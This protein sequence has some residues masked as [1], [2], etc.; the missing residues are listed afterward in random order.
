[1]SGA[2]RTIRRR[3]L[4]SPPRPLPPPPTR[5][6][7]Y[8]RTGLAHLATSSSLALGIGTRRTASSTRLREPVRRS[9]LTAHPTRPRRHTGVSSCKRRENSLGV[10]DHSL[11][12]ANIP[13]LLPGPI[14]TRPS[15]SSPVRRVLTAPNLHLVLSRRHHR[16]CKCYS[17]SGLFGRVHLPTE[18]PIHW[19]C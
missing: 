2:L 4:R 5:P 17:N 18:Y 1:M 8:H 3:P 16:I 6:T 13:A 14:E 15:A 10:R 11:S 9:Q 7:A 19:R 12:G